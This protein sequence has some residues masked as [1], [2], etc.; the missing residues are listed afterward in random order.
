[1]ENQYTEREMA[2]RVLPVMRRLALRKK[3]IDVLVTHAP[4]EGLGDGEDS[5]H[6]GFSVFRKLI[7]A[8]SPRYHLH[9]HQHLSYNYEQKRIEQYSSTTIVNGYNYCVLDMEFPEVEV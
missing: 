6:A 1:M 9:G 2:R 4:A 7:D 5:F 3:R 8:C